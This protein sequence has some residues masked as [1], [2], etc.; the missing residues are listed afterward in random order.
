MGCI[1]GFIGL[2]IYTSLTMLMINGIGLTKPYSISP[3]SAIIASINTVI[4]IY[5]ITAL[6]ARVP[7]HILTKTNII[8][9]VFCSHFLI[10]MFIQEL[11]LGVCNIKHLC[12]D[13]TIH[14]YHFDLYSHGPQ[15]FWL[16]QF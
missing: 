11:G 5:E 12:I 1:L 16:Y 2:A 4:V 6:I 14:E 7:K 8:L 9:I 10:N 3:I 15:D 13:G